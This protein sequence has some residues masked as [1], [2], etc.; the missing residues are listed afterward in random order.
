MLNESFRLTHCGAPDSSLGRFIATYGDRGKTALAFAM[1]ED[2][3]KVLS[4]QMVG[5]RE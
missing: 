5:A 4:K 1:N 2:F 3:S